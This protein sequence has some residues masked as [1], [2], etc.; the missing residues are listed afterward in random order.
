MMDLQTLA[1]LAR[2]NG[3]VDPRVL[4]D[5]Q[6]AEAI[7][8]DPTPREHVGARAAAPAQTAPQPAPQAAPQ[9]D[10][11]RMEADLRRVTAGT[12]ITVERVAADGRPIPPRNFSPLSPP[13]LQALTERRGEPNDMHRPGRA[14]DLDPA[15]AAPHRPR[16]AA[17]YTNTMERELV[18]R[19][20]TTPPRTHDLLDRGESREG[21][22]LRH[23]LLDRGEQI[24]VSQLQYLMD[25][26]S[27][28]PAH[29]EPTAPAPTPAV[30]SP[31]P[32][33]DRSA[34]DQAYATMDAIRQRAMSGD[35]QAQAAIAGLDGDGQFS[36]KDIMKLQ[37][38]GADKMAE[39]Q[40]IAGA[41]NLNGVSTE[42]PRAAT[43]TA[44]VDAPVV[45]AMYRPSTVPDI[46]TPDEGMLR[47]T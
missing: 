29:T 20:M 16:T 22:A 19:G 33:A 9:T 23:D 39:L 5:L 43:Q 24:M 12:G 18:D 38:M 10:I 40:Q 34:D 41:L 7:T 31:A 46:R 32:A 45:D 44:Q 27:T 28:T 35:A 11:D 47:F 26:I 15:L 8:L 14:P 37:L 21:P 6:R 3:G 4:R 17:E 36:V 2:Q 30:A 25:P 42:A 13:V 1:N